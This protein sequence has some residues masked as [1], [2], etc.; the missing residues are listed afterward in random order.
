MRRLSVPWVSGQGT[1]QLI[2]EFKKAVPHAFYYAWAV[3]NALSIVSVKGFESDIISLCR[4]KKYGKARQMIVYR[5][6]RIRKPEAEDLA[7]DL[8]DDPDVRL[9][10]IHALK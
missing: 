4:Q 3:G 1:E 2:E 7:L 5:L 9:H 8:L 10:A 6:D